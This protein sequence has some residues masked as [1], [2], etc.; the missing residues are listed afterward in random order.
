ML[1]QYSS[2]AAV[3]QAVHKLVRCM[4]TDDAYS[5]AGRNRTMQAVRDVIE[6]SFG[7]RKARTVR[8]TLH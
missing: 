4:A 2:D 1:T 7:P 8:I 5:D 3:N 6:A